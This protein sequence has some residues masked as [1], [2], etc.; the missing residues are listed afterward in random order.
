MNDFCFFSANGLLYITVIKKPCTMSIYDTNSGS[1][2]EQK[3]ISL[4]Q[5]FKLKYLYERGVKI[6]IPSI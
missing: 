6:D 1:L 2:I 4:V 5:Y 3:N